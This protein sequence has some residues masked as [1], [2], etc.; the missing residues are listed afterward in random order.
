MIGDHPDRCVIYPYGLWGDNGAPIKGVVDDADGFLVSGPIES[1]LRR[2][3][4]DGVWVLEGEWRGPF[5]KAVVRTRGIIWGVPRG[6]PIP[7][8]DGA[9]V[10]CLMVLL[11][12]MSNPFEDV[13][14]GIEVTVLTGQGEEPCKFIPHRTRVRVVLGASFGRAVYGNNLKIR[15]SKI[16]VE[17]S[18]S[19]AI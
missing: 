7:P 2:N 17:D 12:A 5:L 11:G 4:E 14:S 3:V 13:I 8:T 1:G 9:A 18:N 19:A 15:C 16:Y 10:L 6:V